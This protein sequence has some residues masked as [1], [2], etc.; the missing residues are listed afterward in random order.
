MDEL[1]E[2]RSSEPRLTKLSNDTLSNLPATILRP[3]YDR[4]KLKASIVHIG[5]G[6]FHRAHQAWYLHRLMQSGQAFDWAIVGAGVRSFDEIQR[7]KLEA[8]DYL[9]TLIELGR[10]G[11]SAEVIGAMIDYVQIEENNAALIKRMSSPDIRI[12]SLTV[13]EGG[14]YIDPA[15]K[16]FDAKHPDIL[17]DATNP[18]KPKTAFGAIVTALKFRRG[19]G[20]GPFTGLCC[21]N[22]QGNGDIL[23]QTVVS[24][25]QL[26]D[27]DLADWINS[28]CS[29]P[30]SMVDC[31]VPA[32]GAN[33]L[34]LAKELGVDDAV[35]VTH[36]EFRQWV[37]EDDF[38]AGRPALERVGVTITTNVHDYEA[39][40]IRLLNG[41]HQV[42]ANVGELLGI[43]TIAECMKDA[44]TASLFDKVAREEI[45]PHVKP[46]PGKTPEEYVDLLTYRFGNP[47]IVDTTRRVAFDGSSRHPVFSSHHFATRLQAAP[48]SKDLRW[49]KQH[50][51][52]C[53]RAQGKMAV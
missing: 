24:L 45:A 41:G 9:T 21:D 27:P 15:T 42:I 52:V 51:R 36:E 26:S 35:P 46:V 12:V 5:V 19:A 18:D 53:V 28:N 8:Q 34:R 13:T 50:G 48:R 20:I 17:H 2:E 11:S 14:Y 43:Q 31:I 39:M 23:R 38:C 1:A 4:T 40:K 30:N 29:F 6:N 37:I 3:Q 33:E 10:S 44:Q 16:G 32:T 22:L 25:A 49:L 7:Q 47:R